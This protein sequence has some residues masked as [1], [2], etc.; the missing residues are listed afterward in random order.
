MSEIF[1]LNRETNIKPKVTSRHLQ[2]PARKFT[3]MQPKWVQP[4]SLKINL[5]SLKF[6]NNFITKIHSSNSNPKCISQE[7]RCKETT[8]PKCGPQIPKCISGKECQPRSCNHKNRTKDCSNGTCKAYVLPYLHSYR[9]MAT[10]F[11]TFQIV[12]RLGHVCDCLN[13]K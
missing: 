9:C 2:P 5:T 3:C 6:F 8:Q 13:N 1:I 11:I 10:V 12:Q 4:Q 7:A